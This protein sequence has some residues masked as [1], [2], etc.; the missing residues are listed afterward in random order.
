MKSPCDKLQNGVCTVAREI[1]SAECRP[2]DKTCTA[3]KLST[4]PMG[5]NIVTR[6]LAAATLHQAG[7]TQ[8]A[9]DVLRETMRIQRSKKRRAPRCDA[10]TL[11]AETI[12]EL[13]G[14]KATKGCGCSTLLDEMNRN[15]LD[16]C[17]RNAKPVIIPKLVSSRGMLAASLSISETIINSKLGA[18][19]AKLAATKIV[20]NVLIK[21]K[22]NPHG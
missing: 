13:T 12:T 14:V 7:Q 16:W 6:G 9:S 8:A 20:N 3:C 19:L 2:C 21:A 1:A 17:R 4:N 15:G 5:R 22:D 11:L 18:I 10:G